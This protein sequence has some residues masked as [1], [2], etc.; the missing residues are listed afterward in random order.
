MT[1]SS[2]IYK[3]LF[4]YDEKSKYIN[5]KPIKKYDNLVNTYLDTCNNLYTENIIVKVEKQIF[6]K[7][8]NKFK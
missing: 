1:K 8:Y 7:R 5:V 2:I 6:I 3:D 4:I